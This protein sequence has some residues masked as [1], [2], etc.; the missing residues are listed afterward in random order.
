LLDLALDFGGAT[1]GANFC[2]ISSGATI[3]WFSLI[4]RAAEVA[5]IDILASPEVVGAMQEARARGFIR[6][7]RLRHSELCAFNGMEEQLVDVAAPGEPAAPGA[8]EVDSA[9]TEPAAPD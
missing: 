4:R 8:M 2:D 1:N 7:C 3:G 9:P 5:G 6:S